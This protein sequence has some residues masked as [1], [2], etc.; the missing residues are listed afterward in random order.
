MKHLITLTLITAALAGCATAPTVTQV[1]AIQNACAID[2][3]IRPIVLELQAIPGLVQPAENLAIT[4]ARGI[5]DPIC[6]NPAASPQ[7]NT[8]AALT[9]ASAQIVGIVSSVKQRQAPR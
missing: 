8:L 7:A 1:Q 3:G 4:A 5:I 6:A 2:A 9:G